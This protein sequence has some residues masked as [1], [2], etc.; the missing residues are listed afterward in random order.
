MYSVVSLAVALNLTTPGS[1]TTQTGPVVAIVTRASG[2]KEPPVGTRLRVNTTITLQKGSK[3]IVLHV[4]SGQRMEL[5]GPSEYV[6]QAQGLVWKKGERGTALSSIAKN[7]RKTLPKANEGKSGF[8]R[9]GAILTRG[10]DDPDLG[11]IQLSPVGAL[12]S[13]ET[14]LTWKGYIDGDTISVSFTREATE[15]ANLR[16][17]N[18]AS[19]LEIPASARTPGEVHLVTISVL[20]DGRLRNSTAMSYRYLTPDEA[21]EVSA[22]EASLGENAQKGDPEAVIV[23]CD[24]YLD[25]GLTNRAK[26]LLLK[27]REDQ[28]SQEELEWLANAKKLIP[29]SR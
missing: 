10:D 1:R 4:P 24:R 6:V 17:P 14:K 23:L 5:V 15:V 3:R 21:A 25:L 9:P 7:D 11:P 26:E 28:L 29:T 12:R 19:F 22:L 20:Q 27:L 16:L 18:S 8:S 13:D 2:G